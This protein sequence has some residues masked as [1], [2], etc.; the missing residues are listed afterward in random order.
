MLTDRPIPSEAMVGVLPNLTTNAAVMMSKDATTDIPAM[1]AIMVNKSPRT[2]FGKPGVTVNEMVEAIAFITKKREEAS[3][4]RKQL[5]KT[6]ST[7]AR[8]ERA[9]TVTD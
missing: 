2:G 6:F 7:L 4:L 3:N 8:G 1:N 9:R 5:Q